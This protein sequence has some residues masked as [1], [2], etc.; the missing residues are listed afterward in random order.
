ML[1]YK[2]ISLW[3]NIAQKLCSGIT[4]LCS[5]VLIYSHLAVYKSLVWIWYL[6]WGLPGEVNSSPTESV[7]DFSL[8][9][10]Q[11]LVIS[12]SII[13]RNIVKTTTHIL[14]LSKVGQTSWQCKSRRV[15]KFM[16]NLWQIATC[17]ILCVYP[18]I[19]W[20]LLQT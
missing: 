9:F 10:C 15:D 20:L 13:C 8:Q 4:N 2:N 3:Q 19:L 18:K 17:H 7:H 16:T 1:A 14:G 11:K 6:K 5:I 12:L